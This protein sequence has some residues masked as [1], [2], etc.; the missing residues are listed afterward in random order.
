[1]PQLVSFL[2]QHRVGLLIAAVTLVI[3][4]VLSVLRHSVELI[5]DEGRYHDY[6]KNLLQGFYV[7]DDNPDFVN[8]P[9]YP[10][11]L[12]PFM[13]GPPAWLWARVLNAFFM[14]GAAWF[15]WLTVRHYA[16][17]VWAAAGAL[18][19]A[20]HP[21]LIWMGFSMMTEPLALLCLTAFVWFC[22]AA[23]RAER[24]VWGWIV[25]AAFCLGWLTLTR[26]FFGHVMMAT[27]CLCVLLFPFLKTWRPAL[28][29]MLLILAGAFLLC[30]PYLAYTWQK[31]GDV[32]CWSTNS[33]ELLYWM[34]SHHEGENGHWFST[35]DAQE[36][37]E[38]AAKHADFY[39]KTLKLPVL[40]REAAFKAVAGQS[41]KA[42]PKSVTY[43]WLCNLSRLAFG[44]PRS[45]LVEELRPVVLIAF[46]GTLIL[47]TVLA[48][49]V[50]AWRWQTLPVEIWLL[51][52][53][54]AFYLGGSSLAPALPRY[55]VLMVPVLF[56]GTAAS[57]RRNV[58]VSLSQP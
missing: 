39:A 43:N 1:M 46:N 32:L 36:L 40:E 22:C 45:H 17:G 11:V 25:G 3:Y 27:G 50:A 9:G 8:G 47:L 53:F 58:R 19:T 24:H 41:F 52:A 16:G 5:W 15:V 4:A 23:L 49:A 38:V 29:R 33:G 48:A 12:M 30:L 14:A 20:L 42:D 56:L 34:A 7:T 55:F 35:Q 54:A 57:L 2:R 44:F 28:R 6:A 10:V 13:S 51:M 21:T 26:V 18:M 31:T 37:P